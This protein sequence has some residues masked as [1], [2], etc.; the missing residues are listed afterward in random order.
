MHKNSDRKS[1]D[2]LE[3]PQ[4]S[5][6]YQRNLLNCEVVLKEEPPEQDLTESMETELTG[7]NCD[8]SIGGQ[9]QS[10]GFTDNDSENPQLSYNQLIVKAIQSSAKQKMTL[11]QICKYISGA[12]PNLKQNWHSAIGQNL[13]DN[14]HI[15]Q[16]VDRSSIE[17]PSI[18][19]SSSS[20]WWS[21]NP[22]YK[23]KDG[24]LF[25]ETKQSTELRSSHTSELKP[26]FID[27]KQKRGQK[28]PASD[29]PQ[30]FPENPIGMLQHPVYP[31]LDFLGDNDKSAL[32][33]KDRHGKRCF[34]VKR[35]FVPSCPVGMVDCGQGFHRVPANQERQKAWL[36]AINRE[37]SHSGAYVCSIHFDED[38][39][40]DPKMPLAALANLE[41]DKRMHLRQTAVPK[42]FLE[43]GDDSHLFPTDSGPKTE[44][45]T[46]KIEESEANVPPD[47]PVTNSSEG[48]IL[49]L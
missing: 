29:F 26:N 15:F 35:C 27:T 17:K 14:K 43:L 9:N 38:D 13:V 37:K 48:L 33:S 3:D 18:I 16:R 25:I 44:A 42:Y 24:I 30:L 5:E 6:M 36:K 23:F 45:V 39:Y 2:D 7:N 21:I 28:R 10:H 11:D 12:F 31:V 1:T 49:G 40:A 4:T 20:G 32:S 34:V 41:A 22:S 8:T 47:Q 19:K 46:I